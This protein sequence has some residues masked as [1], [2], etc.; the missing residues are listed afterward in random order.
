M[1]DISHA[2]LSSLHAKFGGE[3]FAPSDPRFGAAR[4]AA[5]WNGDI[6]RQPALIARPASADDVVTALAF[7]RAEGLDVSVRGGGH[8]FAG[9]GVADGAVMIDLGAMKHATL[10]AAARRVRCGGGATWADVDA[11]TSPQGLAVTGGFISHTGVAGLALG[12]GFGWLT[13]MMGMTCDNLVS[14]QVVTADG[15]V[16][17]ASANDNPDLFWALRGGGGNF[18]VVTEFEF[19]LRQVAPMANLGMFFWRPED[20]REALQFARNYLHDVPRDVG[21]LIAGMSA[22][23]APFVP[24]AFNGATGIAVLLASFGTMREHDALV[25]PLRKLAPAFEL[26]TPIPYVDLQQMQND[27]A[28]WGAR[29]YEK[30]LYLDDLSDDVIDI[31]IEHL[32]RKTSPLAFV[33]IFPLGGAYA[34]VAEDATAFGGSR[35]SRWIYNIATVCPDPSWLPADRA[36]VRDYWSALRPHASGDG[37]YINFLAEDDDARTRATYGG[38]YQRLAAIKSV[39]DPDNVFRHNA[40]IKP[41]TVVP[42]PRPVA[43]NSPAPTT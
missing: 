38:K 13:R 1:R 31:T 6:Q 37:G 30:A 29:A 24:E 42:D 25:A 14:A 22:P 11:A 18:G 26:V 10:D 7:A 41:V 5:I 43:G 28:P 15:R 19:A 23:P 33:P 21:G 27:T 20:A 8:A 3:V 9:H 35:R 39:W 40:N 12:G 34:D 32:P 17:A 16:V 4:A 2:A 36:W